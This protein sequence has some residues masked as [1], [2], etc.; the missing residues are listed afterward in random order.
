MPSPVTV[1]YPSRHTLDQFDV[2]IVGAGV[3]GLAIAWQLSRAKRNG[4]S[5]SVVVLE[6][7][8]GFGQHISSHNSEVIHAGI[9]YPPDSLKASLCVAGRQRLYQFCQDYRV[10]HRRLGKFIIAGPHEEAALNM[11]LQNARSSGVASLT[12]VSSVQFV[13]SEPAVRASHV[14]F[15]PDSGILDS[16][17]FMQT[18]LDLAVMT[19]VIFAP[20]SRVTLVSPQQ[21]SFVVCCDI[22]RS[23]PG[24]P[25][26]YRFQ[27]RI[28][29]NCAG[30]QAQALA[31]NIE[32]LDKASIPRLHPCKGTYFI[33]RGK[34]PFK[35][36][37]YPMPEAGVR[38]LGIHGTLDLASQLRFGPNTEYVDALDYSVD[39]GLRTV[40]AEAIR[41]YFP[42]IETERLF[43]AYSGIRPKLSGPDAGFRDFEIQDETRH[44]VPGLIQLFG[45]E[46]PGLTASL[47]IAELVEGRLKD[48]TS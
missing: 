30:L 35:H 44:R 17:G 45:I 15:S 28:V 42:S 3:I 36:L 8:P 46:S 10:N 13:A 32:G 4:K 19:G 40:Y 23:E 29:I 16:H 31:E 11:L 6:Q 38:G 14:L 2:C 21:E 1:S 7:A 39:P 37:I 22:E 24:A 12:P 41:T 47:A 5:L 33:Y 18:L 9:Y 43:P 20:R 26:P 48:L 34:S 27:S 25:E